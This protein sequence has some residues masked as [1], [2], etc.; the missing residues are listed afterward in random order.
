MKGRTNL[1]RGHT[2]HTLYKRQSANRSHCNI[3]GSNAV[4]QVSTLNSLLDTAFE[5]RIPRWLAFKSV[6]RLSFGWCISSV[7]PARGSGF[8]A[9]ICLERY[10][11]PT[12]LCYAVKASVISTVLRRCQSHLLK[13]VDSF[14]RVFRKRA[15]ANET[16]DEAPC[17][18]NSAEL[19]I[20]ETMLHTKHFTP[21][22][23]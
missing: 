14:W 6:G 3:R 16:Q 9:A 8:T 18:Q 11:A 22:R 13:H 7:I 20:L 17:S 12:F 5:A 19:K 2:A 4:C 10:S 15:R 1:S 23:A 21:S